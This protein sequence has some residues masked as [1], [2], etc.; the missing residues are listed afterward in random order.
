MGPLEVLWK[1]PVP[2]F[3]AYVAELF[4]TASRGGS[5]WQACEIH[6]SM[7]TVKTWCHPGYSGFKLEI[8]NIETQVYFS[9]LLGRLD[10][11]FGRARPLFTLD[12]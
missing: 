9:L 6:A 3:P 8:W 11:D 10:S 12:T 2:R 1:R 7:Q 5:Q 4:S